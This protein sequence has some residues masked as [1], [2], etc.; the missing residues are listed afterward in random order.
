MSWLRVD[1]GFTQHP[2]LL[3]LPRG[4]RWTWLDVLC[5]CAKYR[6]DGVVTEAISE[7]VR[8][9]S[10]SFLERCRAQHLL[11]VNIAGEYVVHDWAEYNPKDTS[12]ERSQRYR[13]KRRGASQSRHGDERGDESVDNTEASQSRHG[14]ERDESRDTRA[15]ARARTRPVPSHSRQSVRSEL[16]SEDG[17]TDLHDDIDEQLRRAKEADPF[18]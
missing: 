14:D 11:D 3:K 17:L 9:A 1:D 2:K 10:P 5:Y 15:G 16:R 18:A 7:A 4:D 12:A 6:T 8:G 13:D